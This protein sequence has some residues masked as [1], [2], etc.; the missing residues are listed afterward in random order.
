MHTSRT[1]MNSKLVNFT[2]HLLLV[3]LPKRPPPTG[4]QR[5]VKH[6]KILRKLNPNNESK[7]RGNRRSPRFQ[8]I[9]V[10]AVNTLITP[11]T[12]KVFPV[13]NIPLSSDCHQNMLGISTIPPTHSRHRNPVNKFWRTVIH[14]STINT[15]HL[16]ICEKMGRMKILYGKNLS[17]LLK[18]K[19]A[20]WY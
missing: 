18:T 10:H 7:N 19:M 8:D 9:N 1:Q 5:H 2:Q 14:I 12:N 3:L 4:P 11:S 20:T 17:L 13:N 15:I 6:P 16:S